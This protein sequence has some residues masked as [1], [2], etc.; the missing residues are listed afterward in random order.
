MDDQSWCPSFHTI[1]N[2]YDP[3]GPIFDDKS[4]LWHLFPD[5]CAPDGNSN[6]NNRASRLSVSNWKV[7]IESAVSR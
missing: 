7:V 3:S 1:K 5:G 6:A 4:G 2:H